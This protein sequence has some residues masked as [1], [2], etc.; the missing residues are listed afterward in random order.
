M[1][2]RILDV[3]AQYNKFLLWLQGD[4]SLIHLLSLEEKDE[5]LEVK[6]ANARESLSVA[7]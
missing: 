4:S 7:H 6:E 5:A 2:N 1:E 3:S